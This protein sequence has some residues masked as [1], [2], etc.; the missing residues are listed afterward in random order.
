MG[1]PPGM[2]GLTALPDSQLVQS[3]SGRAVGQHPLARAL[4]L[5][6]K[7]IILFLILLEGS[8]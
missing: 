6:K 2:A 8:H 7:F 4:G 5:G 3:A 1:P